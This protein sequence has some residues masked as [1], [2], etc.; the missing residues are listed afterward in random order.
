MKHQ[1]FPWQIPAGS[2]SPWPLEIRFIKK[3]ALIR[4]S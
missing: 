2:P 3:L 4:R 1:K